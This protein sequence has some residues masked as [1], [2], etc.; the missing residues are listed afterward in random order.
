MTPNHAQKRSYPQIMAVWDKES[1]IYDVCLYEKLS[2]RRFKAL[3][4]IE[5]CNDT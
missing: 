2:V 3:Y 1:W 5:V 4:G